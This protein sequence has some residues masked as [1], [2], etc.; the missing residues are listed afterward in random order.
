MPLIR[1]SARRNQRR[2]GSVS[3]LSS[4]HSIGS[5]PATDRELTLPLLASVE[6]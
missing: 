2:A 3:S 4:S 5:D 6:N 1:T